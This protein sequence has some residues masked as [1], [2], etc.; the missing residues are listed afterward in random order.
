MRIS[1][2]SF[3]LRFN[4]IFLP[5]TKSLFLYFR[6]RWKNNNLPAVIKQNSAVIAGVLAWLNSATLIIYFSARVPSQYDPTK[7]K[8]AELTGRGSVQRNL[9]EVEYFILLLAS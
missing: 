7:F 4:F 6:F 3:F 8:L 9:F 1:V 2:L 5:L